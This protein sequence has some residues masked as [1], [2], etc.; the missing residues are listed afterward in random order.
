MDL[1]PTGNLMRK[2]RLHYILL[3]FCVCLVLSSCR[4][5]QGY[6]LLTFFFDGVPVPETDETAV[7]T[8]KIK[9]E[10]LIRSRDLTEERLYADERPASVHPVYRPDSCRLCHDRNHS[11]RLISPIPDLCY[12]CHTRFSET[13]TFLHGP[14]GAGMCASCHFPHQSPN[15]ALLKQPEREHCLF[16][17]QAGDVTKNIAHDT[18]STVACMQCHDPHGGS[19]VHFIR[20]SDE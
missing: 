5:G 6:R 9:T 15:R 4:A 14:V 2:T 10:N 19:D 1:F 16:C 20:E 8:L 7:D 17:H 13:Y 18:I 3:I 11:N 12:Q